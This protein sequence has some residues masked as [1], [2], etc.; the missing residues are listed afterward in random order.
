MGETVRFFPYDITYRVVDGRA[1]IYLY[2]RAIDDGRR[3]CVIDDSFEPY[4]YA[5]PKPGEDLQALKEKL[6]RISIEEN[7]EALRVVRAEDINKVLRGKEMP[8]LKVTVSLPGAVPK[9]RDVIRNWEMVEAVHEY[10]ILFARRYLI[11]KGLTP[12]TLCEAEGDV[13][14]AKSRIRTLKASRIVQYSEDSY[15]NPRILAVDI[16]TYTPANKAIDT[17]R[18]PILMI[19]LQGE[20]YRKVL[21]WRKFETALDYVEFAESEAAMLEK[22]KEAVE[23]YRP[24]ILTGYYSDGFDLP[25]IKARAEKYRIRLDIGPDYAEPRMRGV[26]D[27]E[28]QIIGMVHIDIFRFIKRVMR[29]SLETEAYTLNAVSRQLLGE[30]KIE[31]NLDELSRDWDANNGL[32]R[33]CEYSMHDAYLAYQLAMRMLPTLTELVK[34]VG[35]PPYDVSRMG[36]SQMVEWYLIRQASG[37]NE[38]APNKPGERDIVQRRAQSLEGG[39][40]FEPKP[41]LYRDIAVFDYLS[42]YPTIISSHNIGPG[43][44]QCACCKDTAKR[45][46]GEEAY[47]FCQKRKGFIPA[48]IGDIITRRVRIKELMKQES[49]EQRIF[50]DARQGALKLMANSFYGYLGFAPARWYSLESAKSTTALGR[51]YIRQVISK[52]QQ[53]GFTVLYSDT[54]SVFL[55]LD[56]KTREGA[57]HFVEGINKDLPGLM[58]MDFEGYYPAGIFVSAKMGPYGAKKKYALLSEKGALKIRGF[59][60]VRR[61]WSPVAKEAQEDVL[62]IILKENDPRKAV[63]HVRQV[64][65]DLRERRIPLKKAVIRMQ[66]VR[67]LMDYTAKGPHVAAAQ[68]LK[69]T[70]AAVGSGTII[71]YVVTAGNDIIRNR[72]KLPEEVQGNDYDAEYYI[73]NQVIPAV[74]RIFDVLGYSREMLAGSHEQKTLAGFF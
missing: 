22:F 73:N 35:L 13:I 52:A 7:G 53:A 62:N 65:R 44:L 37:F 40:V 43:T 30:K 10:D 16:E 19:A 33:F 51:H 71:E 27:K 29:G 69:N 48:L 67:E 57:L 64:I 45:I 32:G 26:D 68:R 8:V 50:L 39:F 63:Q 25:Y 28:C 2:G 47:W 54:D 42:L 59:E 15:K 21:L 56:G 24:D 55:S 58:E 49:G 74:E 1:H 34:I 31:V 17:E 3:I 5:V 61:N 18:N 41:G 72:V 38:I 70:G 20:D 11:D 36:F 14:Q 23:A 46:P 4:F 9:I 60:T 66:L 12:L 6:L